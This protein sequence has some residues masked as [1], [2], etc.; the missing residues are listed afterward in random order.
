MRQCTGKVFIAAFFLQ[1]PPSLVFAACTP[2]PV[3]VCSGATVTKVGNGP[4]SDDWQVTVD[5]NASI[6]TGNEPAISLGDRAIIIIGENAVI[7]NFGINN[8][9]GYG[10]GAN[11][12]E[13]NNQSSLT[14]GV[15]A[16]VEAN[17]PQAFSE[18][19][20]F[21]GDGNVLTNYGTIQGGNSTAIYFQNVNTGLGQNIINNFG[22]ITAG[23]TNEVI[24]Q[25]GTEGIIFTQQTGALLN[26]NLTFGDGDDTLNIYTGSVITGT[27]DGG[28]GANTLTLNGLG[29][30]T[31]SGEFTNFGTLIKQDIGTWTL[32]GSLGN[33]DNAHVANLLT[34]SVIAGK[35]IL[36]GNNANYLGTMTVGPLGI[37]SGSASSLMPFITDNGLVEFNQLINEIYSGIITGSGGVQKIGPGTLTLNNIHSYQ[38][39]TFITQGALVVG[40][41]SNPTAALTGAGPVQVNPN[42]ILTGYG[43]INGVVTNQGILGAGNSL[44]NLAG[45]AVGTLTLGSDLINAGLIN[46]AGQFAI[47]NVLQVNGNYSTGM[48]PGALT[49]ATFLNAGG[50]LANQVTDRLLITGSAADSTRVTVIP[51]LA[52]PFTSPLPSAST[53]IS[54]IQVAG[55]SAQTTFQL[56]NNELIIPSSPYRFQLNAY[57]PGSIYGPADPEQNL[58]GN[59]GSYWD[60][61][62]QSVYMTPSGPV[63][64]NQPVVDSRFAVAPQVPA[65]I[66]A[67]QALFATE[68]EDIS[69]L[70]RRLGEIRNTIDENPK[71]HPE[72]FVRGFGDHLDYST[73]R[74]FAQYGYNFSSRY[75]AVQFGTNLVKVKDSRGTLRIG[76]AGILGDLNY[77]P[78]AIDGSTNNSTHTETLSGLLTWQ[79]QSGW[80]WDFI[81]GGGRFNEHIDSLS[82]TWLARLK[83]NNVDV[84]LETGYP[85]WLNWHQLVLEPELQIVYQQLQ[86]HSQ[87]DINQI[88]IHWQH[89]RQGIFRG[90]LR[91]LRTEDT[92][93]HFITTYLEGNL[94]QGLGGGRII[95]ISNIGFDTGKFGTMLQLRGGLSGHL[96]PRLSIYGDI[97]NQQDM[98]SYGFHGWSYNGGLRY[99]L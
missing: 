69:E 41:A 14:I 62:L 58:V 68:F 25:F 27:V 40:D 24:G 19:V 79:A 55:S 67:P 70:H 49:L 48:L 9:G 83:G 63:L 46:L 13:F 31:L 35:L 91:L 6:T 39:S 34:A 56:L 47:G 32:S 80:Y 37:L 45:N 3:V 74:S 94:L 2:G 65:Y 97:A 93:N 12:I 23:T 90:G 76:V 54:L 84:S 38:G 5:A 96:T 64:P 71:T 81:F 52:A 28:G 26:G 98:A 86:F 7:S 89:P 21:I 50:P 11:T 92:T 75:S 1:L 85:I 51:Y 88:G 15:G 43:L 60:Y 36:T 78:V 20:N 33:Y 17:G 66:S 4:A 8:G 16:R 57:G 77:K 73:S 30:D 42:T 99:M 61:R 44:G 82:Q 22:T 95:R 53:G 10:A 18:A 59:P 72:V 87:S 29:T